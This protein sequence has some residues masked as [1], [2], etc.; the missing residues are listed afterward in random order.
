[1]WGERCPPGPVV[2]H[3]HEPSNKASLTLQPPCAGG[4]LWSHHF[5]QVDH[6]TAVVTHSFKSPTGGTWSACW[7]HLAAKVC[8]SRPPS[9][10][11]GAVHFLFNLN[12]NTKCAVPETLSR[13]SRAG[14]PGHVTHSG[15]SLLRR[16]A[17]FPADEKTCADSNSGQQLPSV[18]RVLQLGHHPPTAVAFRPESSASFH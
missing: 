12:K 1:M 3:F 2:P 6:I 10:P 14:H 7:R 4:R 11:W 8:G 17:I 13:R 18:V 16:I 9:L 15:T 5:G